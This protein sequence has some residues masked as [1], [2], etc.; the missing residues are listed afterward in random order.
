MNKD[1]EEELEEKHITINIESPFLEE[2]KKGIDLGNKIFF[3]CLGAPIFIAAVL[4]LAYF[5]G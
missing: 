3:L 4:L 2:V 5:A 1:N